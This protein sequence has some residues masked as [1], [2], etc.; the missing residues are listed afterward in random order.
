M[1]RITIEVPARGSF[2]PQRHER[3]APTVSS[4]G[5]ERNTFVVIEYSND[6]KELKSKK[7]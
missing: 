6:Q 5:Y 2:S 7:Q 3:V 1:K 4:S